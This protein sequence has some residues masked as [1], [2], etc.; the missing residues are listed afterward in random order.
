[1]T[2]V[3]MLAYELRKRGLNIPNGILRKK[4]EVK[5]YMSMI[6]RACNIYIQSGTA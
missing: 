4:E 1:M 3:T 6:I 5:I 2:Q